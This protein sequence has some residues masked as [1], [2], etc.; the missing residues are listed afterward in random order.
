MHRMRNR[1]L[2]TCWRVNRSTSMALT[3]SRSTTSTV[4]VPPTLPWGAVDGGSTDG[5]GAGYLHI[6]SGRDGTILRT[7]RGTEPEQRFGVHMV[8]MTDVSGDGLRDLVVVSNQ[9]MMIVNPTT[10]DEIQTVNADPDTIENSVVDA[11]DIDGDG[12]PDLLIGSPLYSSRGIPSVRE[13]KAYA[14]SLSRNEVI[15]ERLGELNEIW[16]YARL[17][18]DDTTGD[19]VRELIVLEDAARQ[20]LRIHILDGRTGETLHRMSDNRMPHFGAKLR[21]LGDLNGDGYREFAFRAHFPED[22]WWHGR[23]TVFIHDGAYV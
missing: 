22:G 4:T 8:T 2:S 10:G 21:L 12:S 23:G 11:G 9:G 1:V 13:G 19:G 17:A 7:L 6:H 5:E 3:S 16:G 20:F 15:W 14:Y 18:I